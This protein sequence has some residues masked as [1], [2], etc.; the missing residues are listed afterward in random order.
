MAAEPPE[1][2]E[3][4]ANGNAER[5]RRFRQR[6][7]TRVIEVKEEAYSQLRAICQQKGWT[8]RQAVAEA[9]NLLQAQTDAEARSAAL[10]EM[11]RRAVEKEAKCGA[12]QP[13]TSPGKSGKSKPAP[14]PEK[15]E[16]QE[17]LL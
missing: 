6:H 17:S 4:A 1:P 5:Q 13:A 11:H 7:K 14:E 9:L 12:S 16:G 8:I 10:A 3:S 15:V 2:N